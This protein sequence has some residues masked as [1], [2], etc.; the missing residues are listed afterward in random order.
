MKMLNETLDDVGV[1]AQAVD[2]GLR[3][4]TLGL[5]GFSLWGAVRNLGPAATAQ[6]KKEG[7]PTQ[8]AAGAG[9][10][11][12]ADAVVFCVE[13]RKSAGE[14]L[15]V[16]GGVETWIKDILCLRGGYRSRKGAGTGLSG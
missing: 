4:D 13:A 16:A 11:T 15:E 9:Y 1:T 10:K 5:S 7:L 6:K 8:Y 12:F 14:D 3:Y 2:A